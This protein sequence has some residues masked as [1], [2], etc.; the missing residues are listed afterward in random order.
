MHWAMFMAFSVHAVPSPMWWDPHPCLGLLNKWLS[1]RAPQKCLLEP[2]RRPA[3]ALNI[4]LSFWALFEY[5]TGNARNGGSM[6][7]LGTGKGSV[8]E[9]VLATRR[10]SALAL[11][12]SP[13]ST[14]VSPQSRLASSSGAVSDLKLNPAWV[15]SH[16]RCPGE[17]GTG[18]S[19]IAGAA[20]HQSSLYQHPGTWLNAPGHLK[21]PLATCVWGSDLLTW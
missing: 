10:V 3:E 9:G 15:R 17:S 4:E 13:L 12:S 16:Q 19:L 20:G 11:Q 1:R 2:L 18:Q 14:G 8:T 21:I 7:K 6:S 5:S